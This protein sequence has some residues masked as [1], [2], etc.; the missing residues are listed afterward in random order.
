MVMLAESAASTSPE[1]FAGASSNAILA[2]AGFAS[3]LAD[4]SLQTRRFSLANGAVVYDADAAAHSVHFIQRGQIRIFQTDRLGNSRLCEVLGPGHWFGAAAFAQRDTYG[5]RAVAVGMTVLTEVDVE[6]LLAA[7]SKRPS[8]LVEINRQ[9]A[10]KV[11]AARDDAA[12]LVFS[13]TTSR[14]VNAL[15]RFSASAAA[16]RRED[17]VVVLNM[18]H[19]HLAQA[20][21][22]ARETVSLALTQL[23]HQN[24]V[25]TGRN[26]L[27][28]DIAAL[29]N[30]RDSLMKALVHRVA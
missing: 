23:R 15:L 5:V 8:L 14:L 24:L 25:K 13:D 20:V 7:L 4:P 27:T 11:S 17:G 22:A 18:T 19:S 12:E 26:R 16:I 29:I 3:F 6:S 28:F 9:L 1:P 30:F 21:G 2:H 10:A